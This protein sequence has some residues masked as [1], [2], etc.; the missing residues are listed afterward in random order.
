MQLWRAAEPASECFGKWVGVAGGPAG[1]FV[2]QPL[3]ALVRHSCAW[4]AE[5]AVGALINLLLGSDVSES[6]INELDA[7]SILRPL[8][9]HSPS[10]L[11]E[12]AADTLHVLGHQVQLDKG[13]CR[14]N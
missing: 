3:L 9:R 10:S 2:R 14:N 12:K 5:Q 1:P 11:A 6:K 8:L 7:S 13:T 4:V